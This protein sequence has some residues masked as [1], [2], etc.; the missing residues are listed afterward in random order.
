MNSNSTSGHILVPSLAEQYRDTLKRIYIDTVW[1]P[2]LASSG[3]PVFPVACTCAYKPL[4]LQTHSC[5]WYRSSYSSITLLQE[6]WDSSRPPISE[7]LSWNSPGRGPDRA[8][9]LRTLGSHLPLWPCITLGLCRWAFEGLMAPMQMG[10]GLTWQVVTW[11]PSPVI[12]SVLL[13]GHADQ[14]SHNLTVCPVHFPPV[15]HP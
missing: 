8:F 1:I 7:F 3:S 15:C 6:G 2:P 4:R 11:A 10:L 13:C 5:C 14:L 12:V 9:L